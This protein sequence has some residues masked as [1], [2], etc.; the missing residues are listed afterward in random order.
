[1]FDSVASGESSPIRFD[2]TNNSFTTFR[3][4]HMVMDRPVRPTEF[5]S[6]R[7]AFDSDELLTLLPVR[8]P[9]AGPLLTAPQARRLVMQNTD[10]TESTNGYRPG[11]AFLSRA[12]GFKRDVLVSSLTDWRF[13]W[14]DRIV[15]SLDVE[16]KELEPADLVDSNRFADVR[17]PLSTDQSVGAD[18]TIVGPRTTGSKK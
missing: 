2:L 9:P 16:F 11:I 14:P 15:G 12:I 3:A 18:L 6:V 10:W 13:M 17:V 1:M 8:K 7:N 4:L 5:R